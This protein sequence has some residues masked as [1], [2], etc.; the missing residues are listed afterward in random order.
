MSSVH[1]IAVFSTPKTES[2]W[3]CYCPH[4]SLK[5]SGLHF[6]VDRRNWRPLETISIFA[7]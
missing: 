3:K 5:T 7:S 4:F 1:T 2:F 6:S